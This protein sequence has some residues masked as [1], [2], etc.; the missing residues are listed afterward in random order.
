MN[1]WDA[2]AR[3]GYIKTKS[4]PGYIAQGVIDLSYQ[5]AI[6]ILLFDKENE[7]F[8][9]C[10]HLLMASNFETIIVQTHMVDLF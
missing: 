8:A 6:Y 2:T 3:R 4:K 1:D 5:L 9:S 10:S 7:T